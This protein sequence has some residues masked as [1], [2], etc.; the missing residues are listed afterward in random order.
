MTLSKI[1]QEIGLAKTTVSLVLNG[2]AKQARI[3]DETVRRVEEYCAKVNYLPNIHAHRMCREVVKNFIVLLN[4][5]DG[6]GQNS[7]FSEYNVSQILSGI[8]ETA[9]AA[10]FT[11]GIR[12]Y[13]PDLDEQTIFNGFRSREFDGM[14]YYGMSIPENW[15]KVFAKEKRRIVGIGIEASANVRSVNINNR[16]IS[17]ELTCALIRRGYRKMIYLNGTDLSYPGKERYAGF[18]EALSEN[19]VAF[20]PAKQCIQADFREERAE[21][22]VTALL[23]KKISRPDVIVCANDRMALGAMA[24]LKRAGVAMP[25]EIAVAG[26]DN[27]ELGRYV[28]PGLTTFDNRAYD[29]GT[30]A[31]RKLLDLIAG[32]T[33]DNTIL[34]SQLIIRGSA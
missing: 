10:G 21:A 29:L 27:I 30:A 13:R 32:K 2:K 9:E 4:I 24:A 19:G 28:E 34:K 17:R 23:A 33:A 20:T 7:S 5:H 1:A 11:F 18:L 26:G 22:A 6:V 12:L 25:G 8:S 16:E 14:I 15:I 31:C 3:S